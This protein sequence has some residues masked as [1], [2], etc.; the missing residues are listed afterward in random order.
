[1]NG[2]SYSD[3]ANKEAS[4]EASSEP[5]WSEVADKAAKKAELE[6]DKIKQDAKDS[7]KSNNQ[8]YNNP[9]EKE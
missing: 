7:I 4:N 3:K 6:L 9:T 5:N 8:S 1:M 2:R